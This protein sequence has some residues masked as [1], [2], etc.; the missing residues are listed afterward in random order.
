MGGSQLVESFVV[1]VHEHVRENGLLAAA[2]AN[3]VGTD[4]LRRFLLAEF[5]AQEAEFTTY[6]TLVARFHHEVPGSF[7]VFIANTLMEVRRLL[8]ADVAR[9]VGLVPDEMRQAPISPEVKRFTEF[10]SWVALHAGAGEAA[11]LARTDFLLWCGV[12]EPLAEALADTGA[13]SEVQAYVRQ[14]AEVPPEV[15]DGAAEVIDFGLA[16]GEREEWIT[17]SAPAVEPLLRGFWRFV[18]TG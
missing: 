7:F 15:S 10:I 14:Y 16:T 2:K 9:S 4:Q 8:V 3:Q 12:C 11:L 5:Q 13:P 18:V 6:A 17:R 1:P